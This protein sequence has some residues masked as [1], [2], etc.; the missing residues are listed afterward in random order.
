MTIASRLVWLALAASSVSASGA[1]NITDTLGVGL[2][3]TQLISEVAAASNVTSN[4]APFQFGN[5]TFTLRINVTELSASGLGT[6]V[7]DPV[8]ALSNYILSW[9]GNLTLKEAA[10]QAEGASNST[11]FGAKVMSQPLSLAATNAYDDTNPGSCV[12]PL[13]QKCLD[14]LAQVETIPNGIP[15]EWQIP[16][17][18]DELNAAATYLGPG[19]NIT[20]KYQ[21]VPFAWHSTDVYSNPSMQTVDPVNN[22]A[23]VEVERLH[24]LLFSGV[25]IWPVCLRV[26]DDSENKGSPGVSGATSIKSS[27]SWMSV[28]A[29]LLGVAALV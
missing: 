9:P 5:M 4:T 13:G 11:S 25:K 3:P 18:C 20:S 2:G 15:G 8:I 17:A 28:M 27:A 24:V 7:T 12:A 1:E 6:N 19:D 14:A 10:M 29:G 26:K 23:L 22:G 21:P 16:D